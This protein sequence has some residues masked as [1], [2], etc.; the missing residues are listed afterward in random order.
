MEELILALFMYQPLTD[1]QKRLLSET[2]GHLI[3]LHAI[4]RINSSLDHKAKFIAP[5][6]LSSG[7]GPNPGIIPNL[8][9]HPEDT[10]LEGLLDRFGLNRQPTSP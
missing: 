7:F 10:D 5:A 2:N 8:S 3:T 9:S 1:L 4:M 6:A